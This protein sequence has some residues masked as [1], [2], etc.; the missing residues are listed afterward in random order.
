MKQLVLKC[1]GILG[2]WAKYAGYPQ[3]PSQDK[4]LFAPLHRTRCL[5]QHGKIS[6]DLVGGGLDPSILG[7]IRY[8]PC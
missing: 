5:T 2:T 1:R 8:L 6:R 4:N 3:Y 7:L